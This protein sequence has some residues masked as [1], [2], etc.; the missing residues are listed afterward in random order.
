MIPSYYEECA[1]TNFAD[2]F[3]YVINDCNIEINEF[4]KL[5]LNS[6]II[7]GL[8]HDDVLLLSGQS[9]IEW[10][11][12]FLPINKKVEPTYNNFNR[13]KEF[14][15]GWA[16]AYF[17]MCSPYTLEEIIR[18]VSF[19]KIRSLYSPYH[20]MDI[21]KFFDKMMSLYNATY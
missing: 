17:W 4:E 2:M 18:K 5:F 10:A 13:S 8:N 12:D 20:E 15:T 16:L 6:K 3:D 11:D 21:E 19:E 1:Q 7:K 9:G 14:W